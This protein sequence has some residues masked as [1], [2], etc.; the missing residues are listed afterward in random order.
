MTGEQWNLVSNLFHQALELP[1]AEREALLKQTTHDRE[2]RE[3]VERLLVGDAGAEERNFLSP[4]GSTTDVLADPVPDPFAAARRG[5]HLQCPHCHHAIEVVQA[6]VPLLFTCEL[7]GKTIRTDGQPTPVTEPGQGQTLREE[8]SVTLR[9]FGRFSLIHWL[10]EGTY[11]IVYKAR[12]PQADMERVVALKIPRVG[13]LGTLMEREIFLRDARAAGRLRHPNIVPIFEVGEVEGTPYIVS[14]F[15]DG[16][17]LDYLLADSGPMADFRESARIVAALADALQHAH[18]NNV[19][20]RDVKPGNIM[21][22]LQGRPRLMDFGL[23]KLD[24]TELTIAV[25]GSPLGTPAYMSPEQARGEARQV[26]GRTDVYSLGAVLYFL[27]TG[28]PPFRGTERIIVEKVIHDE[29]PEPRSL[30]DK[31]PRDLQTICQKAMAKVSSK[32]YETANEFKLDLERYL[33]NKPIKARPVGAFE[34]AW[35]LCVRNPRLSIA[36]GTAA[37]SLIAVAIVSTVL[38][39]TR[40]WAENARTRE[41]S[42]ADHQLALQLLERGETGPGLL[43]LE[44][45]LEL[46]RKA[47]DGDLVHAAQANLAAWSLQHPPLNSIFAHPSEVRRAHSSPDG[48]TLV[49]ICADGTALLWDIARNEPI[50]GPL[51]QTGKIRSA[52]FSPDGLKVLTGDEAGSLRFWDPATGQRIGPDF[53]GPGFTLQ[54]VAFGEGGRTVIA[55]GLDGTFRRWDATTGLTLGGVIGAPQPDLDTALIS[56]D[57]LR[58]LVTSESG[59]SWEIRLWDLATGNPIGGPLQHG[60]PVFAAAFSP[61]GKILATGCTDGKVRLWDANTGALVPRSWPCDPRLSRILFSPDGTA[62]VSETGEKTTRIWEV[63]TGATRG[64]ELATGPWDYAAAFSPD[65]RTLAIGGPDGRARLWDATTG[66]PLGLALPHLAWMTHLSFLPDSRSLLTCS[67]ERV[68]RIWSIDAPVAS[69]IALAVP[70]KAKKPVLSADGSVVVAGSAAGEVHFFSG[71]DGRTLQPPWQHGEPVEVV[72]LSE[73]GQTVL[74]GGLRGKVQLRRF[75]DGQTIGPGHQFAGAVVTAAFSRD[76]ST[77]VVSSHDGT[78]VI[79]D[80]RSGLRRGAALSHASRIQLLALSADGSV[81]VT[82]S[83]DDTARLW[84]GSTGAPLGPPLTHRGDVLDLAL[85]PDGR[86]LITADVGGL[87]RLWNVASGQAVF[88]FDHDGRAFVVKF[89]PDGRIAVI[90]GTDGKVRLW[91][92]ETG[93]RKGPILSGIGD[94]VFAV[95]FS[96]DGRLIATGGRQGDIRLWDASNGLPIGPRFGFPGFQ[97]LRLMFHPRRDAL[98]S[99]T[100]DGVARLWTISGPSPGVVSGLTGLELNNR[101]E[102]VTI[103]GPTLRRHR[104]TKPAA[105]P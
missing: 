16:V 21:L 22:N 15:V 39:L 41:L 67:G 40:A 31:I 7:C 6:R 11:G 38:A 12:D 4:P 28:S 51:R 63:A 52:A 97:T 96:P 56:P 74:V 102:V 42:Q 8:P 104:A 54:E 90:G 94:A 77:V 59:E 13:N 103:D 3:Q 65:G 26:D 89:S 100:Q 66:K 30:N 43:W 84:N 44:R 85:S 2:V 98:L 70:G 1:A 82:G 32:R 87:S 36:V 48:K 27:I 86:R 25:S 9:R 49:S 46:A 37:A 79:I 68:V 17:R 29:P 35:R 55:I 88:Q 62:L 76:G 80:P 33:E 34:K 95:A 45:S 72:A 93:L 105:N 57:G 18:D 101:D 50:S 19:K 78:A 10:G 99:F 24:A 75:A 47:G 61:D 69:S 20:H 23:A 53:A 60:G 5:F 73:D 83:T 81:V 64:D 71:V 91:D 92:V 58:G 14:E